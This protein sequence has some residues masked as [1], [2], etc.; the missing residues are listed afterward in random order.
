MIGFLQMMMFLVW[1]CSNSL[2]AQ[3]TMI[4]QLAITA[5]VVS[6]RPPDSGMANWV[7]S[8][9]L[10]VYGSRKE[11]SIKKLSPVYSP[12]AVAEQCRE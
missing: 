3:T 5:C 10:S 12:C 9:R 1:R 4:R 6:D 2:P 8:M 11:D 7:D